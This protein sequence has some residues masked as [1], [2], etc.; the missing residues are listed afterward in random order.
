VKI[1]VTGG[2]GFIGANLCRSLAER[3]DR[4]VALDDLSTGYATSLA[5]TGVQLVAGSVLDRDL[6]ADAAGTATTIVHLAARPS[7]QRSIEDPLKSHDVNVTGTL[8]V[9]EAARLTGAHV[10]LASSSSV[11][12]DVEVPVK[13]EDLPTRPLSPYGAGKLAAEAY[14]LAYAATFQLP[15][16]PMRFFNVY[17]PLQ[18]SGHAYAAVIPAFIDAAM[19]GQTLVVNGDGL[20]TRDFTNVGTVV[21]TLTDAID[22]QVTS[23]TPV[24]LAFGTRTSVLDLTQLIGELLERPVTL[25]HGRER[26]GDIRESQASPVLLRRLFPGIEPLPLSAGLAQTIEWFSSELI[27]VR[28]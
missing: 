21:Q 11:Y 14:T 18:S 6:L 3:G 26:R 22:R 19:R 16:L 27:E 2:A 12:G 4:V 9:L 15:V 24:N 28:A 23:A 17:G 8:N 1:M 7:V 25:R 13:H 20:Q 5:G 10:I